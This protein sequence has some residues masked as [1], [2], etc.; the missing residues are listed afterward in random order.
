MEINFIV[1]RMT[2]LSLTN[3]VVFEQCSN[4]SD[5]GDRTEDNAVKTTGVI[6]HQHQHH[7]TRTNI[8]FHPHRLYFTRTN[9]IFHPHRHH[10]TRTKIIFHPYQLY[11][12]C[13]IVTFFGPHQLGPHQYKP[14]PRKIRTGNKSARCGSKKMII[15]VRGD[16]RN[17]KVTRVARIDLAPKRSAAART[18]RKHTVR[19]SLRR[20]TSNPYF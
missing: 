2:E 14:E 17:G 10:C 19:C 8:I 6:F 11:F 13:T 20:S 7:C 12:T 1:S 15:S 9:I 18:M 5:T 4:P 3:V 16:L